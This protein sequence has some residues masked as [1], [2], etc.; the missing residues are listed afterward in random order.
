[1]PKVRNASAIVA[2]SD[3]DQA[4]RLY[5]DTVGLERVRDGGEDMNRVLGLWT[6]ST[7][8]TVY[9]SEFAGPVRPTPSPG[10]CRATSKLWWPISARRAW[11][12]SGTTFPA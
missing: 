6:G 7:F 9:R 3:I 11:L 10:T 5:Q 2:V 1:M 8:L 12:S 4:R